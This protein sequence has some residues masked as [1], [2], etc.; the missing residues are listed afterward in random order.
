MFQDTGDL[1]DQ[2]IF[3]QLNRTVDA[4]ADKRYVPAYIFRI[5]RC[6]D[7]IEVGECD[8]RVGHNINTRFGGNIGY[9]IH[10]P[11]RGNHY[12]G[13]ACLLLF[14]LARRHGLDTVII[15]CD[16][17]NTAS[18]KTCEYCG[19]NL[20]EIVDVPD[21]HPM[22]KDGSRKTCRYEVKLKESMK[23]EEL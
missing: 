19:A 3:L 20:L 7:G 21:W 15:T 14:K 12:A 17:D 16:P 5:C 8:L 23:I 9:T 2:E 11:Y 1:M 6:S 13:K 18:R 10:E 4:N 22:Y